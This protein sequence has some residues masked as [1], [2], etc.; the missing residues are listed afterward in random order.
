MF[1]LTPLQNGEKFQVQTYKQIRKE[2][3]YNYCIMAVH[4]YT[5]IYTKYT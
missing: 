2:N 4:I 1:T 3:G 5:S